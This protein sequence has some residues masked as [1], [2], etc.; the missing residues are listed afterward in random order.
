MKI[1]LASVLCFILFALPQA[2]GQ[3]RQSI[4]IT[5]GANLSRIHI[6]N[7]VIPI[8]GGTINLNEDFSWQAGAQAG[9]T[10][11]PVVFSRRFSLSTGLALVQRGGTNQPVNPVTGRE[12]ES[13]L[14]LQYLS[15][16][17][18]ARFYATGRFFLEAGPQ[19]GYLLSARSKPKGEDEDFDRKS[20]IDRDFDLGVA[21]GAGFDVHPRLGLFVQYYH[22]LSKVAEFRFTNQ[23]GEPVNVGKEPAWYNRSLQVGL[24]LNVL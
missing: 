12:Q 9:I 20:L 11:V 8:P 2:Y 22:G 19:V 13:I 15:A 1:L 3:A 18:L 21:F 17:I 16:P 6:S 5:M 24:A 14:R 10:A 23:N 7:R 4:G